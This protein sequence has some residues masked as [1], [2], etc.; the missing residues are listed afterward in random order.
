MFP[1]VKELMKKVKTANISCTTCRGKPA[2]R[3]R[4]LLIY[5]VGGNSEDV[6]RSA[7]DK[8]LIS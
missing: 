5:Y 3:V 7:H 1:V 8:D 4:D 6:Q 2:W